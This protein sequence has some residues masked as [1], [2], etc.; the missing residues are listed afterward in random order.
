V[1][2]IDWHL[3]RVRRG[4]A[5]ENEGRQRSKHTR[6]GREGLEILP[7]AQLVTVSRL[8]EQNFEPRFL[9]YRVAT[10]DH[11]LKMASFS[12]PDAFEDAALRNHVLNGDQVTEEDDTNN[13]EENV[14]TMLT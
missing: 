2:V 3:A 8:L 5:S 10:F 12:V 9:E 6:Q 14:E 7:G 4:A 13:E 11:N 1:P